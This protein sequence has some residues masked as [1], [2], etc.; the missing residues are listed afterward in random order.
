MKVIYLD[1]TE[2]NWPSASPSY[3]AGGEDMPAA[4]WLFPAALPP[5]HAR[6]QLH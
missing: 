2:G 3:G 4:C 1:A 5:I 6:R